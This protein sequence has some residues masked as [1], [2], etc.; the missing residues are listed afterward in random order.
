MTWGQ[1]GIASLFTYVLAAILGPHEF[2]LVALGLAF[3]EL[4]QVVVEQGISTA[5]IQR[6]RLDDEHL[7]SA[8]WLSLV[9]CLLLAGATIAASGWWA[10]ANDAPELQG[11]I[12]ALSVSVV[13]VGLM[14]VPLS[15]L[16]RDV[17][18][19]ELAACWNVAALAGGASGLVLALLGAGV[20]ALVAQQVVM[21]AVALVGM[22]AATRWL[23]RSRF[24]RRHARELLG[25]SVSVLAANLGGFANR[26]ADTLL[27][28]LFFGP[29]AVGLYRLADRVVEL[30]LELTMRPVA[31]IALPHFSRFQG[32]PARLRATLA[33]C[34]RLTLVIAVPAL[35]VVA[36]TSENL[37]ALLGDEW[38]SAADVLALLCVVG[39]VKALVLL[40]GPLLFAVA[41]PFLRAVMLWALGALSAV[42][43]VAVGLALE[44]APPD[45]QILGMAASRVLLFL[46][47][48]LPLSLAILVKF[49]G[50]R[51]RALVRSLPAA[52]VGGLSAFGVVAALDVS[53]ILDL[54]SPFPAA[55]LAVATAG[56][57]AFAPLLVLDPGARS[58]LRSLHARRAAPS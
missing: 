19:R 44:D 9:W 45:D 14:I 12:V 7:D 30:V 38:V 51:L 4:V 5:L 32:D 39:I 35:L 18:F 17:R 52:L 24:S 15:L 8:F 13:I 49:G 2:G 22:W 57:A 43:V 55:A 27:M 1:R 20:W 28:G 36:A 50:L 25:F 26:R 33:R 11:V 40:S 29:A 3:V 37:L 58:E 31:L 41:R 34:V 21:D 6:E 54:L 46:A 56:V 16:Q 53:G 10:E 47:A 42:T 48:V 23:P